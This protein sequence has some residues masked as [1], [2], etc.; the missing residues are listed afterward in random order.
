MLGPSGSGKSTLTLCLDGLIPHLVN[1]DYS[2]E[3]VLAGLVVNDSPVHLLAQEAG[4]VF[5]DPDAQF[6]TLTVEDEIAF[7]SGESVPP[8][9]RD[10]D[11]HRQALSA[12]SAWKGIVSVA[13]PPCPVVRS[14]GSLWPR[15]WPWAHAC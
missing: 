7:G 9:G 4:L 8:P 15:F 11:G 5:Q 12:G 10:R 1:G 3:V 6:C 13:W 2:G 14:S